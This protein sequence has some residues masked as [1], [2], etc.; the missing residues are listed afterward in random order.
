MEKIKELFHKHPYYFVGG[1]FLVVVLLWLWLR[2]GSKAAPAA[3][4][5]NSGYY[6]AAAAA[7]NSGNQLQQAQAGYAAQV[8]QSTIAADEAKAIAETTAKVQQA[9]IAAAA[10]VAKVVSNNNLATAG[11]V[12]NNNLATAGL[13]SVMNQHIA[14]LQN[15]QTQNEIA[16][17]AQKQ[18]LDYGIAQNKIALLDAISGRGQVVNASVAA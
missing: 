12:S 2:S 3:G 14:D 18:G 8:N 7:V 5:D 10:D 16:L 13:V 15:S 9:G 17:I 6:A 1:V 11:L 4:V